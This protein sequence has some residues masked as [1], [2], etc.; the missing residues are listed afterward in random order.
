M[1]DELRI[2]HERLPRVAAH[3]PRLETR[4]TRLLEACARLGTDVAEGE[5]RG[6]HRDFYPDQ[7]IVDGERL[8]LVDFDLYC[9]GDPALD[10]GNF[11]GHLTEQSLRVACDPHAFVDREA[12]LEDQFIALAGDH[13][14]RARVRVYAALTLV[15]HIELSTRF[16]ERR[17][18]TD[19]L[20]S[21]SEVRVAQ[22]YEPCSRTL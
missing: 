2:L 10:I 17:A 7:V 15:R 11:L 9:A 14:A 5:T 6:I 12:A 4:L 13:Q 18:F 3:N 16:T 19:A 20:L 22:A 8:Y 21:L 1:A